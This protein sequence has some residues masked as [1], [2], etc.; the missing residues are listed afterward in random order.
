M[1][2]YNYDKKNN[3]DIWKEIKEKE[4]TYNIINEIAKKSHRD[5]KTRNTLDNIKLVHKYKEHKEKLLPCFRGG[6]HTIMGGVFQIWLTL[7][8]LGRS[9]DNKARNRSNS[10]RRRK[11]Q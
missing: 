2:K 3:T 7:G 9:R 5:S 11:R 4:A 8:H 6:N 1:I 10:I